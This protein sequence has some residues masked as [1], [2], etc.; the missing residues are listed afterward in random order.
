MQRQAH[1]ADA[2]P[3]Q[4]AQELRDAAESIENGGPVYRYCQ[5]VD[6]D[7]EEHVRVQLMV[8]F[9]PTMP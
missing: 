5:R 7:A 9:T 4:L 3:K 8:E 2:E 6:I 1:A